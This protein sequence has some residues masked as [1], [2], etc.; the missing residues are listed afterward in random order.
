M[1]GMAVTQ[2][3]PVPLRRAN[4]V[5]ETEADDAAKEVLLEEA[6]NKDVADEADVSTD[7]YTHHQ[8]GTSR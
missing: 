8:L 3:S 2:Q 7:L 5:Q 4:Q 1:S 6:F